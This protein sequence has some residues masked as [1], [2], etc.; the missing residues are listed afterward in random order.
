MRRIAEQASEL[1]RLREESKTTIEK[2]STLQAEVVD[3]TAKLRLAEHQV[4]TSEAELDRCRIQMKAPCISLGAQGFD[5]S[6]VQDCQPMSSESG[7]RN[8]SDLLRRKLLDCHNASTKAELRIGPPPVDWK[9]LLQLR[10]RRPEMVWEPALLR[11]ALPGS[12]EDA[13]FVG[14]LWS[15]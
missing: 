13:D 12:C 5:V 11:L 4:T 10:L 2:I 9:V 3:L 8:G 1:N 14:L 7:S 15:T 6:W